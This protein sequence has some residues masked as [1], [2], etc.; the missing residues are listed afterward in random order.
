M[1]ACHEQEKKSFVITLT[2]VS[3]VRPVEAV[4]SSVT[5]PAA[6]DALSAA[7]AELQGRALVGGSGV[8][9][10]CATVLGPL[11]RAVGAVGVAVAGPQARNADGVV[12]PEGRGAA[13]DGRAGGL[14][15]AV[16]TVRLLVAHE[17]GRHTLAVPA[18]ELGVCAL[19]WC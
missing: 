11:V 16:V 13:G 7:T 3:F 1:T 18:A 17:G 8:G 6:V 15:A 14:V 4:S 2:A 9:S 19:L 12:A 5:L 10:L